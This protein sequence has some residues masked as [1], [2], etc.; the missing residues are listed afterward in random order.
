MQVWEE[1]GGSLPRLDGAVAG[2]AFAILWTGL[3]GE[4]EGLPSMLAT[5]FAEAAGFDGR[6]KWVLSSRVTYEYRR[7]PT[8]LSLGR[9]P[10]LVTRTSE[11]WN[12]VPSWRFSSHLLGCSS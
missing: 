1:L 8:K 6:Q 2:A 7:S 9:Y 5:T 4:K 11:R 10:E 3:R 12:F